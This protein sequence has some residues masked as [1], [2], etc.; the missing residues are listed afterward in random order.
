MTS[1]NTLVMYILLRK[2]G[3]NRNLSFHTSTVITDNMLWKFTIEVFEKENKKTFKPNAR[4][5]N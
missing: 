1:R 5:K 4:V 3:F 2:F